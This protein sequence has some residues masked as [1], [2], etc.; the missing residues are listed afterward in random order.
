[1]L[2]LALLCFVFVA[3]LNF[4]CSS[5]CFLLLHFSYF[6]LCFDLLCFSSFCLCFAF[7]WFVLLCSFP[8]RFSYY[9]KLYFLSTFRM[10]QGAFRSGPLS[11]NITWWGAVCLRFRRWNI[12]PLAIYN[13]QNIWTLALLGRW[14]ETQPS[15]ERSRCCFGGVLKK[16]RARLCHS[17]FH[18]VL[19]HLMT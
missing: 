17:P 7:C 13:R 18:Y 1:M 12:T 3:L 4:H 2:C 6:C 9:K 10:Q 14:R 8:L 16:F 19:P 15:D 5:L 11:S